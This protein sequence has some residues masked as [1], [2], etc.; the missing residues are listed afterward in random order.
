[1]RLA[2][3]L[4]CL[5]AALAG[6]FAAPAFAA[7]GGIPWRTWQDNVFAQA[8]AE[9][10]FVIL[11]LGAVWCHWC[12]VMERETYANPDVV[13]LVAKHYLPVHADQDA[14]PDLAARYGDWGW[15]ATIILA[16]D[17]SELAKRRGFIPPANMVSLL[18]AIVDDPTPGPSVH[19]ETPIDAAS[20]PLTAP[21]RA[22]LST[23]F[24]EAYD[25][26]NGGW[27][28]GLKFID[29]PAMELALE[30]ARLGDAQAERLARQTLDANL[31]LIDPVWG[32]VYQYSDQIDWHSPHFE[33]IISFQADDLRLYALAY[34]RFA[35]PKYLKA[36]QDI[37]RYLRDFLTAPSG[38][39]YVSQDADLNHDVSGHDYYAK[40]EDERRGLGLP[41][42]DQH[43]YARENGLAIAALCAFHDATGD[44]QSLDDATRAARWVLK[45]RGLPGGGFRHDARDR[46]GPL[47]GDSVAMSAALL[48]LY[49]SSGDAAWLRQSVTALKFVDTHFRDAAGG[50]FTAPTAKRASGVFAKPVRIYEENLA[51]TRLANLA[52]R[53]SGDAKLRAIAAQGLA[54]LAAPALIDSGR[55]LPGVLLA[56]Q[57][58]GGEPVHITVV[59][60]RDDPAAKAL[61]AEALRYPASYQRVEFWDRSEGAL[62]NADVKYPKLARAAA[63]ACSGGACSSPV[64]EAAK[65]APAVDRVARVPAVREN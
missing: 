1:M 10:R 52:F 59:G 8:K 14:N 49:R 35:D 55:F 32:G 18:Q 46:A 16:P 63:F 51:L 15:P 44:V 22:A 21:Q 56:D 34:A 17:G 7:N 29:A 2:V 5:I 38:A 53:Y 48:A 12:H 61:F 65:L 23:Q 28:R 9:N 50:Y 3:R 25:A 40:P 24:S 6:L 19:P 4:L 42:I 41:K 58:L 20:G 57:E 60:G 26:D 13:A 62:P 47:L 39:F 45:N 43:L 27:G 54:F 33:K 11:D 64:F 31:N 37:R 36:A 30:R